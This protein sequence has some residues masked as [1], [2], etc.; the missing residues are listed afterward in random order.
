M[1]KE[2]KESWCRIKKKEK[3]ILDIFYL[4]IAE[5]GKIIVYNLT[6]NDICF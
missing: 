2:F 5:E 6:E 3:L 1:S 4:E